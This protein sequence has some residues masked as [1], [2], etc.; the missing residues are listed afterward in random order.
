VPHKLVLAAGVR[1]L[2]SA[3]AFNHA[4]KKAGIVELIFIKLMPSERMSLRLEKFRN[5]LNL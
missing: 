1:N 4:S 5:F 2:L 3:N